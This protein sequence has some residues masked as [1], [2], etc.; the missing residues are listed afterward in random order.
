MM[1]GE[2]TDKLRHLAGERQL[3]RQF[4]SDQSVWRGGDWNGS[5]SI[6]VARLLAPM[7]EGLI[8]V[9]LASIRDD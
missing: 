7:I 3:Q 1:M 4:G 8:G 2:A 9:D 6:T 5:V